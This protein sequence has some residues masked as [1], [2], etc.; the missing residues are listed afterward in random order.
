MKKSYIVVLLLIMSFSLFACTKAAG[1]DNIQ[2]GKSAYE[3]AVD[4]G[5]VGSEKEWLLS[6]K[7]DKGERGAQGEQG[8]QGEQGKQGEQGIQGVQGERGEKGEQG[9]QGQQG[10]QGERGAQGE[11]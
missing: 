3:I 8:V 6:L 2:N 5:F 10:I 11:Q 4:N 9:K 1:T 7:G